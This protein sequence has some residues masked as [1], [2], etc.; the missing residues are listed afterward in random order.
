MDD[1]LF[2][3]ASVTRYARAARGSVRLEWLPGGHGDYWAAPGADD[4][5]MHRAWLERRL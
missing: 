3:R 1:P 2:S 4:A 5:G